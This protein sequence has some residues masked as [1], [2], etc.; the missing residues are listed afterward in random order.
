MPS[1][2]LVARE[3]AELF[4]VV[5][6]D[7]KRVL[8]GLNADHCLSGGTRYD[9]RIEALRAAVAALPAEAIN[10]PKASEGPIPKPAEQ[11]P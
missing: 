1:R 6:D 2:Q 7:V 10:E 9:T 3:L 5:N 4:K 8:A 11:S